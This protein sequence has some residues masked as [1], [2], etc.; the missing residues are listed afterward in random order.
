MRLIANAHEKENNMSERNYI[1]EYCEKNGIPYNNE[2]TVY[3]AMGDIS[4]PKGVL[5][6]IL[7]NGDHLAERDIITDVEQNAP[8]GTLPKYYKH[9][10]A[11][12][13]AQKFD[14]ITDYPTYLQTVN[15]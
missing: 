5:T 10:Q 11:L 1:A 15:G 8:P 13:D 3:N 12:Q 2:V 4:E 9:I 7:P 14:D 6:L